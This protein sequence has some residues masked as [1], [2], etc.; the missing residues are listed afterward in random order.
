M[1]H[2]QHSQRKYTKRA[3]TNSDR[4]LLQ[5]ELRERLELVLVLREG[6]HVYSSWLRRTSSSSLSTHIE[7]LSAICTASYNHRATG[8]RNYESAFH[9]ASSILG[10]RNII[11]E[12]T[13]A[14]VWPISYGWAPT[15][16][17]NFNINWAAQ[18]VPFPRFGLQL[19]DD[20]STDD[21]MIE[22]E[23]KVNAMIGEYT[24]NE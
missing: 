18:E 13:A 14:Q 17:V 12:F 5:D 9:L 19:R 4:A 16:I 21:F 20:Q 24:M 23:R 7:A 2:F 1:L 6:G 8:I 3:Y 15:E 11:E 10:G 22:V